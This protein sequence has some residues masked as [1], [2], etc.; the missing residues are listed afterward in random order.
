MRTRRALLLLRPLLSARPL[1]LA[2]LLLAGSALAQKVTTNY[3]HAATFSNYHTYA[4]TDGTP[5]SDPL[6]DQRIRDSV[7]RQLASRGYQKVSDP[8]QADILVAYDAAVGQQAELNPAGMGS[9]SYGWGAG[10]RM[11]ST[12]A[13]HIPAG[14]LDIRIGDN[15]THRI[16]WCGT[17]SRVLNN[18]SSEKVSLQIQRVTARMFVKYP[19]K[20]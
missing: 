12:T 5:A 7:N 16:V 10:D 15:K 3:D 11:S 19:P 8:G 14:T 4:W 18:T 20:K 2:L 9:W 17:A 13:N 1:L 6:T